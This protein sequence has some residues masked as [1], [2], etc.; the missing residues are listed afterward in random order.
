MSK[1]GVDVGKRRFLTGA[2]VA[3]GGV[4]A[5]FVATPFIQSW[6]PSARARAEGAPV[7][8]NIA[9]LE[10]GSM[11]SVIWRGKPVW[12]VRRTDAML[13]TLDAVAS[14]LADPESKTEQQP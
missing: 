9:E 8:V 4:G 2:T 13:D 10:E 7:E 11:M 14:E 3:V 5:A 12:V 1:Q 6:M